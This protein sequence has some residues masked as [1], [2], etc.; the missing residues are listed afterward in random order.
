[1]EC[2]IEAWISPSEG[3]IRTSFDYQ[4]TSSLLISSQ[5]PLVSMTEVGVEF[6]GVVFHSF[7]FSPLLI[8]PGMGHVSWAQPNGHDLLS[9]DLEFW[10]SDLGLKGVTESHSPAW[11]PW[12]PERCCI[13]CSASWLFPRLVL[14]HLS[15]PVS[16]TAIPCLLMLSIANFC[17]SQPRTL[18]KIPT[19]NLKI[20]DIY[21]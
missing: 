20:A 15:N 1:M 5:F 16:L 21:A 18:T 2:I 8:Q 7:F 9:W 19:L 10:A 12:V 3:W 17:C 6:Q 13:C 4:C 14:Q 11:L